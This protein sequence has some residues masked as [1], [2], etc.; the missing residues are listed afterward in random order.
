MS[1]PL[2]PLI[3]DWGS[4]KPKVTVLMKYWDAQWWALTISEN[5]IA[6]LTV[7]EIED[8]QVYYKGETAV[9]W[10]PQREWKKSVEQQKVWTL[11][12][13]LKLNQFFGT[14][15]SIFV[16][17]LEHQ[18]VL[19]YIRNCLEWKTDSYDEYL[20][21]RRSSEAKRNCT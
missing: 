17:P 12:Q 21:I 5:V 15:E 18:T 1:L 2:L 13:F 4:F 6:I 20:F 19:D 3:R 11:G 16:E 7:L 9:E 8:S 10:M 14:W